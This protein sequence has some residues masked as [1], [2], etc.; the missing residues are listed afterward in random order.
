[1]AQEATTKSACALLAALGDSKASRHV[2]AA[3]A[4]ALWRIL[5]TPQAM[6]QQYD[7]ELREEVSA[8]VEA[9][10]PAL[11]AQVGADMNGQP[12]RS[13]ASLVP[14]EVNIMAN[15]AKHTY[16]LQQPF[17][18]LQPR[19]ARRMQRCSR[20]NKLKATQG[21]QGEKGKQDDFNEPKDNDPKESPVTQLQ[22]EEKHTTKNDMIDDHGTLEARARQLEAQLAESQQQLQQ[23]VQHAT[24]DR[25][26]VEQKLKHQLNEE[27][28]AQDQVRQRLLA[29]ERAVHA[30]LDLPLWDGNI[31]AADRQA[32]ARLAMIVGSASDVAP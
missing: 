7:P 14:V 26:H 11:A 2:V 18:A 28:V 4:V 32:W 22:A 13:A 30:V 10:L 3:T 19:E 9:V 17:S 12:S 8:R 20:Q 21:K 31:S 29:L 16:G 5:A 6:V 27:R 23:Q 15:A 25:D 1:M 24:E